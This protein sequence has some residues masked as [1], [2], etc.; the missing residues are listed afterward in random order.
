MVERLEA[1]QEVA[2]EALSKAQMTMADQLQTLA[3]AVA[4]IS[5]DR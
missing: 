3:L 1:K 5:K 4:E 2:F